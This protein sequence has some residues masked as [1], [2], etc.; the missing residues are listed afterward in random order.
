M[1][2]DDALTQKVVGPG[3]D[4]NAG[5]GMSFR[6]EPK[7]FTGQTRQKSF[8]NAISSTGKLG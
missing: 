7:Y 1:G 3:N 2:T 4:A 5:H 6:L 8:S